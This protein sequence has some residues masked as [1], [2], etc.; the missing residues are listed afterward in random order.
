MSSRMPLPVWLIW[1]MEL[2]RCFFFFQAEDGIRDADVTGVQTC[3]LPIY[4][5]SGK[6]CLKAHFDV[7]VQGGLVGAVLGRG[8]PVLIVEGEAYAFTGFKFDSAY[9]GGAVVGERPGQVFSFR[10]IG[11]EVVVPPKEVPFFGQ[12]IAAH[13]GISEAVVFLFKVAVKLVV[14]LGTKRKGAHFLPRKK[15]DGTLIDA[16]GGVV[17]IEAQGEA[18]QRLCGGSARH[19][20]GVVVLER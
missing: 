5:G 4:V 17:A 20:K 9:E 1:C 10:N 7:E 19:F 16:F 18:F 11:V 8:V 6:G 12:R 3:A 2:S 14:V 13:Q 15:A